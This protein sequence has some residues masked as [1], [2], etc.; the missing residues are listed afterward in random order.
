MSR[1][2]LW[3]VLM[4]V[5]GAAAPAYALHENEVWRSEWGVGRQVAVNPTDNSVWAAVGSRVYHLAADGTEVSRTELWTPYAVAVNPTDG[6]CWVADDTTPGPGGGFELMALRHLDASGGFSTAIADRY[7]HLMS[8]SVN[9]Q[10]GS[11][12]VASEQSVEQGRG[13]LEHLILF[14]SIIATAWIILGNITI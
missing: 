11:L 5:L 2:W 12:W 7:T 1:H 10:D 3:L 13:T 8:V 6:S 9:P 14:S 4:G